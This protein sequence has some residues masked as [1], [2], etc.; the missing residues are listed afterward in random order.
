MK[1]AVIGDIIVDKYIIGSC[2][3][4]SPEAP[5]PIIQEEQEKFVLGGAANVFANLIDLRADTLLIG[6]VGFDGAGD[7]VR[8]TTGSEGVLQRNIQT[9][10]KT[11]IVSGNQH[12]VRVDN[13]ENY[14]FDQDD[15]VETLRLLDDFKP[16]AIIV[17]DYGKGFVNHDLIKLIRHHNCLLVADPKDSLFLFDGFDTV[18]P[19][20]KEYKTNPMVDNILVT[21]GSKGMKLITTDKEYE[22]PSV[23]REV[24]DVTG[25]GDTVV[26]VYTYFRCKGLGPLASARYA[27]AAAGIVVGKFG[28]STISISE[29]KDVINPF[30]GIKNN[31][32][33]VKKVWGKEIWFANSPL[34]CGKILYLNKGYICSYHYHKLKNETFYILSGKVEM[35]LN[36]TKVTLLKGESVDLKP[37]DKHSFAGIKSSVILE[38]SS[39]HIEDDSYRETQSRIWNRYAQGK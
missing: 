24:Y 32:K 33:I 37:Y 19:N 16:D 5:V 28:T 18:T 30:N 12:I 15:G 14:W 10:I 11:R 17:S 7:F 3:R 13:E 38:V 27:N 31:L 1:I 8:L 25:A 23:A 34:Y 20:E 35:I 29:I 21:L 6:A 22:I 39:Q 2:E 9:T 36:G 4:V 26:A